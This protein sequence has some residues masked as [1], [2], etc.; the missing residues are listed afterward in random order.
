MKVG[1]YYPPPRVIAQWI[2]LHLLKDYAYDRHYFRI[3]VLFCR[4]LFVPEPNNKIYQY[5]PICTNKHI[6]WLGKNKFV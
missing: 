6:F 2:Y 5:L 3:S 1:S 4:I